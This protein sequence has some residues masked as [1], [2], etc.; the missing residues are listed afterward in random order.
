MGFRGV[1]PVAVSIFLRELRGIWPKARPK[2]SRIAVEVGR[3][4]GIGG[5]EKVE[6]QLVRIGLEY[7]KKRRCEA[8]PV[9][10]NCAEKT[11][12]S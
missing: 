7:C 12:E 3:R 9:S 6:S 10:E 8:C 5:V 11:A 1:G 2:P 4:L